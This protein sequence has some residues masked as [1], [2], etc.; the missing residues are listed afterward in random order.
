MNKKNNQRSRLTR[1][2]LKNAYMQLLAESKTNKISIKSICE[3]AEVNRS[4]FYLYYT[5]PND[6]LMEL[7]DEALH[8]VTESL[9]S[10]SS[11]NESFSDAEAYLLSFL[12]CLRDNDKLLRTLLIENSDPHFR[13]NLHAVALEMAR[14]SFDVNLD[15][16]FKSDIYQF[17]VSGSLELLT[18]WIRNGYQLSEHDM[19][20][21][22][23][24]LSEGSL[25]NFVGRKL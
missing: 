10:I 2:L 21:L 3:Q 22:L 17:I 16:A 15:P 23:F 11:L 18:D 6:I 8:L 5:E 20:R 1:L 19:C 14:T 9:N 24:L 4:T 25:K 7:E 12:K 13:R